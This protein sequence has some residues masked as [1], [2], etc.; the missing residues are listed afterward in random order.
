M[1]MDN[2]VVDEGWYDEEW[3][4]ANTSF[5]FLVDLETNYLARDHEI[6]E[7]RTRGVPAGGLVMQG[8]VNVGVLSAMEGMAEQGVDNPYLVWDPRPEQARVVSRRGRAAAA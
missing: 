1:A 3:M 2:V 5:P 8:M 6:A 7:G 4:L